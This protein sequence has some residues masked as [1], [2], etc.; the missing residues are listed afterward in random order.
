[1]LDTEK[2]REAIRRE[3]LGGWL[4]CSFKGRDLLS[5]SVLDVDPSAKNTRPW[6][7]AVFSDAEPVA[8][9][10]AIEAGILDHLPGKRFVYKSRE[11]L[12]K[13]FRSEVVPRLAGRALACQFSPELPVVSYL[14][15][16]TAVFFEWLGIGLAS[17]ASL[18]QRFVGTL[19]EAGIASHER[20]AA[21]LYEIVHLVWD[22][23][24]RDFA[25]SNP[26]YEGDVKRWILD[27][28]D[29]RGLVVDGSPIVACGP[30]AGNPH[31][32]VTGRGNPVS[33][34]SVL[35]L[36][37]WAKE[38]AQG[39]IY[40]DISWVCFTGSKPPA[41]VE[42][43]AADL[44]RVRNEIVGFIGAGLRRGNLTGADVDRHARSLL[45]EAGLGE[46]LR[47]RTGHGIDV[48]N[49]GSGVNLDSVEFPDPRLL[50]EGSWFSVE[51]G[52]YF[53]DYGLRTEIDVFIRGGKPVVSGGAPQERILT[54]D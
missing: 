20:S 30:G 48:E 45:V 34:D 3:N 23:V 25:S 41:E 1:L 40:A 18:I 53:R 4:F 13:I 7:Y 14:D 19:D 15:H 9:V 21:H 2:M 10:H 44:F 36:D 28:F 54:F 27:E 17:S 42:R 46:A 22:R 16:G 43:N 39:S 31:Y 5:R 6:Y 37:I 29:R 26:P 47:H 33:P 35:Q 11:E 32:S 50:L 24:K 38:N 52:I 49:H 12:E 8:V 51:P